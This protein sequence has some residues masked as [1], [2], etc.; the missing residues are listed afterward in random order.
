MMTC[1]ANITESYKTKANASVPQQGNAT[2]AKIRLTT[3]FSI[4]WILHNI[5]NY[6]LSGK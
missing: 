2:R 1:G 4:I 6:P 3:L 5:L